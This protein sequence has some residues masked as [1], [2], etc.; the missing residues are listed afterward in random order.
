MPDPPTCEKA[1]TCHSRLSVRRFVYAGRNI[2]HEADAVARDA[3]QDAASA[4]ST[5]PW[6]LRPDALTPSTRPKYSDTCLFRGI[7]DKAFVAVCC[8]EAAVPMTRSAKAGTPS[9]PALLGRQAPVVCNFVSMRS[10]TTS[11]KMHCP[12]S[13]ATSSHTAIP[14]KGMCVKGGTKTARLALDV[15][16]IQPG[17]ARRLDGLGTATPLAV[18]AGLCTEVQRPVS[19]RSS[20]PER[21]S[22][23]RQGV[24]VYVWHGPGS[25]RRD[26]TWPAKARR[27]LNRGPFRRPSAAMARM[28]PENEATKRHGRS[29]YP[30]NPRLGMED[31][32]RQRLD[33][34]R[35][36]S[37]HA[38]A[39]KGCRSNTKVPAGAHSCSVTT[40]MMLRRMRC[41]SPMP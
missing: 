37:F 36:Q 12:A 18:G 29:P 11:I 20:S 19:H 34:E 28:A 13:P 1:V 24:A 31:S 4:P 7:A 32:K 17:F 26:T 27:R 38:V 22:A 9:R 21:G 33:R 15:Y 35:R 14:S 25:R 2:T 8:L 39:G 23:I 16:G 3:P 40:S 10:C 5:P 6:L 41:R 30:A